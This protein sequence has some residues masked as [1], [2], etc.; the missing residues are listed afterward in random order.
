MLHNIYNRPALQEMNVQLKLPLL[1][2]RK[3]ES[4]DIS[5]SVALKDT[6]FVI[7]GLLSNT[8]YHFVPARR[9]A[10]SCLLLRPSW[11]W[12][13]L[14]LFTPFMGPDGSSY[15]YGGRFLHLG[16]VTTQG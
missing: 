12:T 14:P 10:F 9:N 2:R 7:E 8:V 11:D 3:K 1:A 4:A 15:H 5:K 16:A 13:A 6:K